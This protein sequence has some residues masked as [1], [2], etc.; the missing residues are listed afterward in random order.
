VIDDQNSVIDW[1]GPAASGWRWAWGLALAVILVCAGLFA[2]AWGRAPWVMPAT[3]SALM[4][5]ALGTAIGFLPVMRRA[6]AC[7]VRIDFPRRM[8]ELRDVVVRNGLA[9]RRHERLQLPFGAVRW[10]DDIASL[11]PGRNKR[12]V[13]LFLGTTSGEVSIVSGDPRFCTVVADALNRVPD[14]TTP[15]SVWR[16]ST[17][18][19][20]LLGLGLFVASLAA[21]AAFMAGE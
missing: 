1:E 6:R 14:G 15:P 20:V 10:V 11:S 2:A 4:L 7:G 19:A 18:T 3:L 9:F 17:V 16:P 21:F 5:A 13:A 8:L 12:P